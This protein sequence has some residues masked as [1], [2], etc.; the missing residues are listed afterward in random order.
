MEYVIGGMFAIATIATAYVTIDSSIACKVFFLHSER[1]IQKRVF[2]AKVKK[3]VF[4][5]LAL[6]IVL[7]EIKIIFDNSNIFSILKMN[8]SLLCLAGAGCVDAREERIPNVFPATLALGAIAIHTICVALGTDGA[9][10]YVSSSIFATI[11]CALCLAL[12]YLITKH[13][14]GLGDIKLVCAL[15]MMCGVYVI[16]GTL[17]FG[18]LT[19]ALFAMFLIVFKKK[20]SKSYLPFGPFLFL[21]YILTIFLASY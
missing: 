3:I 20:S 4:A 13:G 15:S 9:I 2:S 16:C 19:S 7:S 17:F 1:A 11:I 8:I 6:L 14:I 18:I 10:A 5:I 21:G 12:V